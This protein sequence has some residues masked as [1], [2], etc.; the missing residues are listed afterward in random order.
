MSDPLEHP[1]HRP[2]VPRARLT[3]F[4]PGRKAR[5][6]ATAAATA[7]VARARETATA[8]R[9]RGDGDVK[10]DCR[11]ARCRPKVASQMGPLEAA[12]RSMFVSGVPPSGWRPSCEE[13]REAGPA[14]R[15]LTFITS[16]CSQQ[17]EQRGGGGENNVEADE[18]VYLSADEGIDDETDT[19]T[20]SQEFI[21]YRR[22]LTCSR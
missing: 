19:L 16:L 21:G 10:C 18:S 17:P 11:I 5:A 3:D 1:L 9:Q 14:L 4:G 12:L 8:R 2:M 15:S 22:R 7:A 20:E 13:E 6:T